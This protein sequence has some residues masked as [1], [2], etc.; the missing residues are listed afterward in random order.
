[1]HRGNLTLSRR[2]EV[3]DVSMALLGKYYGY[4]P[5][6][7]VF[8]Y[9]AYKRDGRDQ[10]FE[11]IR[12]SPRTYVASLPFGLSLNRSHAARYFAE[13]AWTPF[14][15]IVRAC[16]RGLARMPDG[17]GVADDCSPAPCGAAAAPAQPIAE[18]DPARGGNLLGPDA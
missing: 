4:V 15:G 18:C 9:L 2:G 7:W 11:P 14:R 10:F 13:W 12:Y 6:L 1:M 8:G 16:M 17:P 3:F 5:F